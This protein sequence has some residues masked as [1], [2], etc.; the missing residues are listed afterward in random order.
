MAEVMTE[1]T[2]IGTESKPEKESTITT[3]TSKKMKFWS[4]NKDPSDKHSRRPP[5]RLE[6][7]VQYTVMSI[8]PQTLVYSGQWR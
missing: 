1:V 6:V 3:D 2:A 8:S 4:K 7:Y 5:G